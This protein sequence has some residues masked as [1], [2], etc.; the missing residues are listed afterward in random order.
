MKSYDN[1]TS[2]L[3]AIQSYFVLVTPSI[4]QTLAEHVVLPNIK[5]L[6]RKH[7]YKFKFCFTTIRYAHDW[8]NVL[9]CAFWSCYYKSTPLVL[10]VWFLS[11]MYTVSTVVNEAIPGCKLR[12][13]NVNKAKFLHTFYL[14][15]CCLMRSFLL[16]NLDLLYIFLNNNVVS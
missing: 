1:G 10:N 16:L 7:L 3:S 14:K 4:I 11:M 6:N 9:P 12:H 13:W 5:C 2:I 15:T 8:E